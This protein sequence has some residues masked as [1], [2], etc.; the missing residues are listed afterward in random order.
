MYNVSNKQHIGLPET[1]RAV[2]VDFNLNIDGT[3]ITITKPVVYRYS[4]PDKG[5]L[6]RPFEIIPKV[7]A[8]LSD[9][10]Y[11]FD[12][13]QQKEIEVI[14]KAHQDV[15]EGYVELDH[16][17]GW[18]IYPQK[19]KL[20][21]VNKGDIQKFVFTVIPPR[22][23]NEGNITPKVT[24]GNA[25]Y[26]DE[27]IEIDYEHIPFQTVLLPAKSKVVRLD[28]KKE[29]NSIGYL[30]GAGD[31]V[32][33]SLRQIGYNVTIIKPEQISPQNL[34]NFDA[35]VVGIRAYNIVDE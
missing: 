34:S 11:I 8:S 5:E 2:F 14:V 1:P 23:Q 27:L 22:F 20:E 24:V 15:I 4:K 18:N 32:P 10:V 25:T 35:I 16:P 26:S 17:E 9:K 7:S 21:I 19:Q 28:I 33:E 31:V 13:D 3:P 30:E 6:Y 12:T 29:G